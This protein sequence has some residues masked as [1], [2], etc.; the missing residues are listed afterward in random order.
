MK[1]FSHL[2]IR[3]DGKNLQVIDQR[4]LP[5][6]EQWIRIDTPQSMIDAIKSLAVRGAPLIGVAAALPLSLF[7]KR[8]GGLVDTH[9]AGMALRVAR[10]TAVNL[11]VAMDR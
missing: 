5:D 7:P 1:P 10:P 11:M 6:V 2:A 3:F 8:A 9:E 4:L